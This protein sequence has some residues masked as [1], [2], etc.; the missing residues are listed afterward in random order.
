MR[1]FAAL[2]IT[3]HSNGRGSAGNCGALYHFRPAF[4]LL[5]A[6]R[7]RCPRKNLELIHFMSAETP[8]GLHVFEATHQKVVPLGAAASNRELFEPFAEHGVERSIARF[9][10]Q[11]RLLD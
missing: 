6:R 7:C 4:R 8:P 1:A 10:R 11:A 5:N 2:G 9:G 3:I